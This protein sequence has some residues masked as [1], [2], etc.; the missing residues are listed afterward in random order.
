MKIEK[1]LNPLGCVSQ[2]LDRHGWNGAPEECV[3]TSRPNNPDTLQTPQWKKSHPYPS[4]SFSSNFSECWKIDGKYDRVT[5][6]LQ[7]SGIKWGRSPCGIA[8]NLPTLTSELSPQ[9]QHA[10]EPQATVV[11][12]GEGQ[13]H[14]VLWQ[15]VV[16]FLDLQALSCPLWNLTLNKTDVWQV[17]LGSFLGEL[18]PEQNLTLSRTIRSQHKAYFD[19]ITISVMTS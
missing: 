13:R 10:E 4:T 18:L 16:F 6:W 15:I 2:D 5:P 7:A 19:V 1:N 8:C 3:R 9:E 14:F 17:N 12:Q 11:H